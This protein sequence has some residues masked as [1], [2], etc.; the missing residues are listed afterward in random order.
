MLQQGGD[1]SPDR[2]QV[3]DLI[4]SSGRRCTA[5]VKQMLTF[6]RGSREES[7][8]VPLRHL[9]QEM[10]GIARDTFPKNIDVQ[11]TFPKDLWNVQ[12]NGTELHQILLN[13]CVNARD[14]MPQGGQ[15]VIS[16]ENVA[17]S[18][19]LLADAPPGSYVS[20]TVSDTGSGISP[21]VRARLFE[22][23]FTT[24]G[25][26]RGTGLGLSTVASIV[27]RHKGF[28]EVRSEVGKG[29]E[30]KIYIP[31]APTVDAAPV[32]PTASTLPFGHGELILLVDDE[33]SILE[34]GRSALENYGYGVVTAANGLEALASF[35]L[36]KSDISIIVMDTDMPYLDGAGAL[37]SIRKTGSEVPVI[38]ASATDPDT[39]FLSRTELS[40]V[41]R[42]VK[43]YGIPDLLHKV[44]IVLK[45][46]GTTDC[47]SGG[48]AE[49]AAL[50]EV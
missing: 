23:F 4:E 2:R 1:N 15:L 17:L 43:P 31:A 46:T 48:V 42:L 10:A 13:L 38:L 41:E 18:E 32:D 47:S 16:A 19:Q 28:I 24:K 50:A 39:S 12:G 22:P 9:I 30:F 49:P 33:Q 26:T 7:S 11:R 14:A 3:L 35:E 20:L 27:K 34:I 37:Q 45:G 8:A 36:H 21:E 40:R 29:T 5:L 25:P 6:A 44:A